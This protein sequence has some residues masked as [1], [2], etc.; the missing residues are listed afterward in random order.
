MLLSMWDVQRANSVPS[1]LVRPASLLSQWRGISVSAGWLSRK[2]RLRGNLPFAPGLS[3][4]RRRWIVK[5]P[6]W[7]RWQSSETKSDH[8]KKVRR[9]TDQLMKRQEAE[10]QQ[11]NEAETRK[12]R[13]AN[14]SPPIAPELLPEPRSPQP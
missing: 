9:Q 8:L 6:K 5:K 4:Y 14:G 1:R 7:L 12:A 2:W 11:R 13:P 10:K 3:V